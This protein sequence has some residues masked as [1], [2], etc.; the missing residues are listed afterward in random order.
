[1]WSLHT[2]SRQIPLATAQGTIVR[3]A[4]PLFAVAQFRLLGCQQA[5]HT[6]LASPVMRCARVKRCHPVRCA[7]E[8]CWDPP[9]EPVFINT[10]SGVSSAAVSLATATHIGIDTE[11]KPVFSR[12]TPRQPPALLQIAALHTDGHV[13]P[14][15]FVFDLL[16][17]LPAHAD[18]V[19]DA[20]GGPLGGDCLVLGVGLDADI[21]ALHSAYPEC[22]AF[23]KVM[24]VVD[25]GRVKD[26][27]QLWS[28]R[29]LAQEFAGVTLTKAQQ[30]SDWSR[31][32]LSPAQLNYAAGDAR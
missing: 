6:A 5:T 20:L 16:A 2:S 17:L 31:R 25:L 3:R 15:V 9:I 18:I 21:R 8:T 30:I 1:M 11:T 7:V 29:R 27:K 24:G 22:D 28:A 19:N 12:S 23:R 26:E 32:P 14:R 13:S 4:T 10:P